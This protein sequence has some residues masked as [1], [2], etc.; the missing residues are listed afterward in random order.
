MLRAGPGGLGRIFYLLATLAFAANVAAPGL[1]HGCGATQGLAG[2]WIGH[3]AAAHGL[4]HGHAP[5]TSHPAPPGSSEECH[6]V[7]DM[8]GAAAAAL[9]PSLPSLAAA[10]V[11][12]ARA[13]APALAPR[14]V[15][16]RPPHLLPVA[17][18]PPLLSSPQAG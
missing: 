13:A 12:S 4:A 7:D 16:S 5:S 6:C 10:T 1:M 17:L 2:V 15:V 9:L 8:C 18:A 14:M 3:G 11:D